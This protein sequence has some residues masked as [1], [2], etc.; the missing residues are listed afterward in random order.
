MRPSLQVIRSLER[1]FLNFSPFKFTQSNRR[2]PVGRFLR[3]SSDL[4]ASALR[5]ARG[6]RGGRGLGESLAEQAGWQL[7]G[8][9]WRPP[10]AGVSHHRVARAIQG[11]FSALAVASLLVALS[12]WLSGGA[13]GESAGNMADCTSCCVPYSPYSDPHAKYALRAA[14]SSASARPCALCPARAGPPAA[15][16]HVAAAAACC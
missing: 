10:R 4:P 14:A 1:W 13:V 6:V 7:D 5:C 16:S 15:R 12:C 2:S 8:T 9:S 3:R 11:V